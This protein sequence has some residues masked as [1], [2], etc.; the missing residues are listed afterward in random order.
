MTTT[1]YSVAVDVNLT[2]TEITEMDAQEI[3]NQ[4]YKS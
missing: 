3:D 1:D 2:I 4:K